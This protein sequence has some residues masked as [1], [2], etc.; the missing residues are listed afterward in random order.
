MGLS[1]IKTM[2]MLVTTMAGGSAQP[3]TPSY[4]A[5]KLLLAKQSANTSSDIWALS[6]TLVELFSDVPIWNTPEKSDKDPVEYIMEQMRLNA[7]PNGNL[8]LWL[9]QIFVVSWG[10]V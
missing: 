5:P 4:Q 2:N 10:K 8:L 9:M 1:K 7:R 3:G 6:C